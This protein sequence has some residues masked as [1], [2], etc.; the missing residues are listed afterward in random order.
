MR[1]KHEIKQMENKH[2]H[3]VHEYDRDKVVLETTVIKLT[4]VRETMVIKLI[5]HT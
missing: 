5:S 3:L 4:F 1:R 2:K